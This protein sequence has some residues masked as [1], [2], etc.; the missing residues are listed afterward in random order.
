MTAQKDGPDRTVATIFDEVPFLYD[1]ARPG[2]PAAAID[3]A[4]AL[5]AVPHAGRVL[6]VG[7]GT[8][9]A[10]LPMAAR[11][12]R[13]TAIEPGRRM[14]A[15]LARKLRPYPGCRV[16]TGRFEDWKV[17]P[18]SFD[19]VISATAFHWV[20][21]VL[22]FRLAADALRPSGAIALIRNDH[23][24]GP[25]S[26][27]YYRRAKGLYD[28]FAPELGERFRVRA[29]SEIHGSAEEMNGSGY[30]EVVAERRYR[31]E[32]RYTSGRLLELL[33]TYS[34]HRSLAPAA[35]ASLFDAIG[36]LIDGELGGSFVDH[37]LTTLCIARKTR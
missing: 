17:E 36:R 12:L 22:R 11:G 20:E 30:F 9:Q 16:V 26:D 37:Y 35:R 21:P 18:S 33:G 31:W 15:L 32:E 3:D 14:A 27:V 34:D 4:I 5:G 25:G 19:L 7:P 10:T 23:V 28:R 6:E 29:E 2:Y 1:R 24:A 8:G 13:V